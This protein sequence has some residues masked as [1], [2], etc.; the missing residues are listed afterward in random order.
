VSILLLSVLVPS[1]LKIP[2]S[3]LTHVNRSE[4]RF[5]CLDSLRVFIPKVCNF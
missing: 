3:C 1:D 5:T 4:V 2:T